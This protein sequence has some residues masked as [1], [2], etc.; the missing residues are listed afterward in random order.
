L[1]QW[2]S[3]VHSDMSVVAQWL[4]ERA[5]PAEAQLMVTL[6]RALEQW[7]DEEAVSRTING[8]AGETRCRR[9]GAHDEAASVS[10]S[11]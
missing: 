3:F 4:A 7:H 11:Q 10:R 5:R 2:K 6:F 1:V 8:V 9:G